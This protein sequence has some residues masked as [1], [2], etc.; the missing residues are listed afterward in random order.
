VRSRTELERRGRAALGRPVRYNLLVDDTSEEAKHVLLE[1]IR[2]MSP[3]QRVEE[4]ARL[5][6]FCREMMRAGIRARHPEYDAGQVEEALAR[7]LWGDDLYRA[8]KPGRPLLE[9]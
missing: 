8:A 3:A 2:R 4:G 5:S 9:P 7:L 1:R 6:R